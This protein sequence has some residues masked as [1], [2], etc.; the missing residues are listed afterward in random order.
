MTQDRD[1]RDDDR[2]DFPLDYYPG[3][4]Y[5]TDIMANLPPM[6]GFLKSEF[7][8]SKEISLDHATEED[9]QALLRAIEEEG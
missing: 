1:S 5:Y 6:V 7:D 4:S 2:D 3:L 8:N 9:W